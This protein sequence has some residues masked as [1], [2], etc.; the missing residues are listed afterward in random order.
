MFVRV[1][2]FVLCVPNVIS[3]QLHFAFRLGI[4]VDV[5]FA[6]PLLRFNFAIS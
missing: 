4:E 2:C 6:Q 1:T 3:Q 5:G